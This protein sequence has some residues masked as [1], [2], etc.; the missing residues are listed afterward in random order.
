[1]GENGLCGLWQFNRESKSDPCEPSLAWAYSTCSFE[2]PPQSEA[3]RESV[4]NAEWCLLLT[5][6]YIAFLLRISIR[7]FIYYND[8]SWNFSAIYDL[9]YFCEYVSESFLSQFF[10]FFR[11]VKNWGSFL[12]SQ[13]FQYFFIDYFPLNSPFFFLPWLN[14]HDNRALTR[15]LFILWG[16]CIH[17][18]CTNV[19]HLKFTQLYVNYIFFLFCHLGL[20]PLRQFFL[21][22]L[23]LHFI[24]FFLNMFFE[25]FETYRKVG[26]MWYN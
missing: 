22:R 7:C 5:Y 1:M 2:T 10:F 3:V 11:Y 21:T 13:H 20:L 17:T 25:C 12:T 18:V 24:Y 9:F 16:K 23:D 8:L 15:L 26:R 19:V 14:T 6:I 4:Q